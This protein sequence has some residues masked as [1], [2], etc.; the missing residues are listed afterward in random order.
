[1]N[2]DSANAG[3]EL[4]EIVTTAIRKRMTFMPNKIAI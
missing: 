3:R 2:P 1:M 4:R